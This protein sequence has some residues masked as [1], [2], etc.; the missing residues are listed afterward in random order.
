MGCCG[1]RSSFPIAGESGH[2]PQVA[3]E[4][5]YDNEVFLFPVLDSNAGPRTRRRGLA[6]FGLRVI[7]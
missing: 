3:A 6:T 1:Y 5:R 7:E 2:T 4:E